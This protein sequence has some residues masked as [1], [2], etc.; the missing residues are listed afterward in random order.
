[1]ATLS[2]KASAGSLGQ[3]LPLSIRQDVFGVYG[4]NNVTRSLQ[5]QLD[6]IQNR[7]F[8]RLALVTVL[9]AGSTPTPYANLQRDL[10]NANEVWQRECNAWIYCVGSIVDTSGVLGND[11]VLDQPGCPLGVQASPTTEE[12]QLFNLGRNLGADVVGYFIGG[13]TDPGLIGCSAYPAGQR[14]FWVAFSANEWTLAHELTHVVGLNA[15]PQN[16]PDIPDNDQD[17]LMWPAPGAIT[18]LPPDLVA[19][20]VNRIVN[21]AGIE[22]TSD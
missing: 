7:P 19:V 8:I 14:G 2:V 21:D 15:H 16:D 3:T 12:N 6:L 13:S 20:Q 11:S 22:T 18:N 17:N 1:M 5:A 9:A 4:T 10:D